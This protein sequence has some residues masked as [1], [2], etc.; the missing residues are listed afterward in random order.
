MN[1]PDTAAQAADA[2]PALMGRLGAQAKAASAAMARATAA[3]KSQVLRDLAGLLRAHAGPLGAANGRDLERAR[4]G[5]LSGPMLDRL[6]LDAK[7][8]ET[9]ALGCEQLAG[10][11][12]VI[13]EIIGMRQQP[14]EVAQD[15]AFLGCRGPGH[16]GRRGFGLR[17][18]PAHQLWQRLGSLGGRI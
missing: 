8:L 2:L 18:E 16:G 14:S 6:K 3:Q 12:D 5:G 4:A 15:L 10:M 13:G 7:T 11:A 9:V 1:A 17:T